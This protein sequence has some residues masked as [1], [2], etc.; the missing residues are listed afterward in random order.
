VWDIYKRRLASLLKHY[1]LNKRKARNAAIKS[2][3]KILQIH[4]YY[5]GQNP[6][7]RELIQARKRLVEDVQKAKEEVKPPHMR[8]AYDKMSRQERCTA[9]FARMYKAGYEPQFIA[10]MEVTPDWS[11]PDEKEWRADGSARTVTSNEDILSEVSVYYK[12]LF[13]EKDTTAAGRQLAYHLLKKTPINAPSA[14]ECGKDFELK[15]VRETLKKTARRKA[16]GPDELPGGV[17]RT[18][19]NLLSPILLGVL[20]EAKRNGK[21][22]PS[23]MKGQICVLYKKGERGDIRN[24][25]PI[26][27]L[28]SDYK[29]FTKMLADRMKATCH[30]WTDPAQTGFSPWRFISEST[31]H[32]KLIQQYLDSTN[33]PGAFVFLDM[34]KA[35]DRVSWRFLLGGL[36]SLGYDEEFIGMVRMMYD[37]DNPPER[38][39]LING[40]AGEYFPIRSGVAQGCPLSPLLFLVCAEVI[41]RLAKKNLRGIDIEGIRYQVSAFADDT[42]LM[43]HGKR[44]LKKIRGILRWYNEATGM[45]ANVK[46]T[47]GLLMGSLRGKVMPNN[48]IIAPDQW[49]KDGEVI[50][51][52]GVPFGNEVDYEAFW[53]GKYNKMKVRIS[54]WRSVKC[55]TAKGRVL[56]SKM[57][58]W[59]RFRY[60]AQSLT[61]PNRVIDAIQGDIDALVWARDPEFL[62]SEEGTAAPFKRWM[63]QEAS[64]RKWG[65]GG[66]GITCWKTHIK[67]LLQRW[68]TRYLDATQAHYKQLLDIYIRDQHTGGRGVILSSTPTKDILDHLPKGGAYGYWAAAIRAFRELG[69]RPLPANKDETLTGAA[70]GAEPTFTNLRGEILAIR[71]A[72]HPSLWRSMEVPGVIRRVMRKGLGCFT[73][74]DCF[75]PVR[76]KWWN[77]NQMSIFIDRAGCSCQHLK[78]DLLYEWTSLKA[79]LPRE[80]LRAMRIDTPHPGV[81]DIV[82]VGNTYFRSGMYGHLEE[83]RIDVMGRPFTTGVTTRQGLVGNMQ[84]VTWW[85]EGVLGPTEDTFPRPTGWILDTSDGTEEVDLTELTVKRAYEL[86]LDAKAPRPMCEVNWRRY[87]NFQLPWDDIW[88][89]LLRPGIYTPHHYMTFFKVLHRALPTNTRFQGSGRCRLGCGCTEHFTHWAGGGCRLLRSFWREVTHTMTTFGC[90]TYKPTK[91]LI[92]FTLKRV[93]GELVPINRHMR[94]I[95]WLAWKFLWQ[96]LAEIGNDSTGVFSATAALKGMWR[97][98]H[99]AVLGALYDYKLV[100]QDKA[101]GAR[102]I[103]KRDQEQAETYRVWPFVKI[104]AEGP[105]GPYRLVYTKTYYNILETQGITPSQDILPP[106]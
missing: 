72:F 59:S 29:I 14:K 74:K 93:Q 103:C 24:Y 56:L 58:V 19:L 70:M 97:M 45:K 69:L 49:A 2:A 90:G 52:L 33:K 16:P 44:D 85:G 17:Y 98:H 91:I 27:L 7:T 51:S 38:R 66:L 84:A 96:Q 64:L 35:F 28:N 54:N 40:K 95:I 20:N 22:P 83:V 32:S 76:K 60:W 10:E 4:E 18:F 8:N 9:N 106:T 67:S 63:T 105:A 55:R 30:Q 31:H 37:T 92:F 48:S 102:K 75:D 78:G 39:I 12:H 13:D 42:V 36:R 11:N 99:T 47:E 62:A 94:G 79:E 88:G 100:Q 43:I 61:M 3:I 50:I 65:T 34:E 82:A 57:F 23:F 101:S 1:S 87:I 104:D 26:T 77:H 6:P 5:M 81:G 15:E 25:R 68:M 86:F 46:K 73:L 21:L 89:T 71:R 80:W 41:I 53:M